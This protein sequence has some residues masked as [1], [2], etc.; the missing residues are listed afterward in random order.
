MVISDTQAR[1]DVLVTATAVTAVILLRM[2]SRTNTMR[3]T[4]TAYTIKMAMTK[5]I[6][7]AVYD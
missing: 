7:L 3:A 2:K 4:G 5:G 1:R 6:Q